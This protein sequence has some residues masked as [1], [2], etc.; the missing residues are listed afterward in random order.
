M[1]A[2]NTIVALHTGQ[3]STLIP[4][5]LL[6]S[7]DQ[8]TYDVL[9]RERGLGG[10]E[11]GCPAPVLLAPHPVLVIRER[12]LLRPSVLVEPLESPPAQRHLAECLQRIGRGV[13]F[14]AL[15]VRLAKQPAAPEHL[16]HA[17]AARGHHLRELRSRRRLDEVKPRSAAALVTGVYAVDG[18]RM[19]LRVAVEA[20]AASLNEGHGPRL[21]LVRAE[22]SASLAIEAKHHA[23]HGITALSTS[24]LDASSN[25]SS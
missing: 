19:Q 12:L 7:S 24:L 23:H 2:S 6:I 14:V 3:Q 20:A 15:V 11:I 10:S 5:V 4:K 22:L 17:L 18:D 25:R 9:V 8:G 13:G 21:R 16:A 1:T